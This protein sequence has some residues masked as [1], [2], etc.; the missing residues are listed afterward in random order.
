M[1]KSFTLTLL[2]LFFGSLVF[3]QTE[4]ERS[5]KP[6]MDDCKSLIADIES[7]NEEIVRMEFDIVKDKKETFRTL[8]DAY[9]YGITVVGD[10]RIK[11]M[12]IELYS[13]DYTD[14]NTWSLVKV[15]N[16]DKYYA[17][18]TVKPSVTKRYKIVV[19]ALKFDDDNTVGH[20]G[21]LI[22]HE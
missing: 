20:Y 4:K 22:Y 5:M 7:K 15:E 12:G 13:E 18:V 16:A 9:T 10:Y 3:A 19:K 14:S 17:S 2:A 11:E 8:T 1:T 21:L 6:I